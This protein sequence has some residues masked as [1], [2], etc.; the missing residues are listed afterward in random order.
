[1]TERKY[2]SVLFECC[3]IYRRIYLN[4]EGTAYVGL[5]PKCGLRAHIVIDKDEGTDSRIFRVR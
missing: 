4:R 3:N 5:C 2:L 1:M